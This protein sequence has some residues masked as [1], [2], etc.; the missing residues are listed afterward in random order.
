M[1]HRWQAWV[2]MKLPLWS[3]L[4]TRLKKQLRH[5]VF[6]YIAFRTA[7]NC[8]WK[9]AWK[10]ERC[11][12]QNLSVTRWTTRIKAAN[13]IFKKTVE[14]RKT[15]ESFNSDNSIS[16]GTKPRYTEPSNVF[17]R[18]SH[19]L[20]YMRQGGCLL[21]WRSFKGTSVSYHFCRL[22]IFIL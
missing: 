1:G 3:V 8:L 4:H 9:M 20:V 10:N 2:L 12:Q 22:C 14:E 17:F 7:M 19:Y 21:C 15:L 16:G 13:A 5:V 6:T 18:Y 11:S